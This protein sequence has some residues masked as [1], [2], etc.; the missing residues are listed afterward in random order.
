MTYIHKD[1]TPVFGGMIKIDFR[2]T[3][4][5]FCLKSIVFD[6]RYPPYGIEV[7]KHDLR[8]NKNGSRHA[9]VMLHNAFVLYPYRNGKPFYFKKTA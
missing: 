3:A 8:I 6:Y 2:E 9:I 1:D 5:A 4:D 7:L